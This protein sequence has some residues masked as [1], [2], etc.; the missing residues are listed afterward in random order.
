MPYII[1]D[2]TAYRDN[3]LPWS[4][5]ITRNIPIEF[6]NVPLDCAYANGELEELARADG[7]IA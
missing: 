3:K 2:T 4:K 5:K 7:L 6:V 1:F